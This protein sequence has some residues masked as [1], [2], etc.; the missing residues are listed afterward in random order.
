LKI[1]KNIIPVSGHIVLSLV[2]LH[3]LG[4]EAIAAEGQDSWR[5]LFDEIMRWLNFAILAF[6]L[7]KFGRVP[8]KNFFKTRKEEMVSEIKTLENEKQEALREI[9]KNLKL[10][11]D[12]GERFEALKERIVAQGEK[13]KQKIIE[14]A[15]QESKALLEGAKQKIDSQ[16]VE[17]RNKLKKE[18]IDSAI[19]IAM[20]RLPAE[21]T[22][23]DNQKWVDRFLSNTGTK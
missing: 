3:L 12:S 13:N 4:L 16:I 18:L 8:I 20:E 23:E 9:D 21:M 2:C 1:A 6:L 19:A 17:A 10:L 5:P 14:D 15:K 11:E 22:A 7:I